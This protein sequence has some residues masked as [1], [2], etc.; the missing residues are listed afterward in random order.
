MTAPM[1]RPV[2]WEMVLVLVSMVVV[3][4]ALP[5]ARRE[6]WTGRVAFLAIA[7]SV[8][9]VWG[10]LIRGLTRAFLTWWRNRSDSRSR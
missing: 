7:V 2:T 9:G 4:I 3:A 10:L 6:D 8:L 1:T 5:F